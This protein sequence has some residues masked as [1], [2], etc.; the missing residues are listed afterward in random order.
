MY[1]KYMVER[2]DQYV[3][4]S[5]ADLTNR[6]AFRRIHATL[7]SEHGANSRVAIYNGGVIAVDSDDTR[8][9]EKIR[10]HFGGEKKVPYSLIFAQ[11]IGNNPDE[12]PVKA[13][14]FHADSADF[15]VTVRMRRFGPAAIAAAEIK[16]EDLHT[17]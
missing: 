9:D 4:A 2:F 6:A 8:F 17:E 12:A 15:E 16:P 1:Y 14:L 10:D 5:N 7:L 3:E 13:L 11:I